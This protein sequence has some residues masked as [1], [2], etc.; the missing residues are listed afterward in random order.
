MKKQHILIIGGGLAG[1]CSAIQCIDA[2]HSV[3]LIDKG[4]NRSSLVA[5]GMINP[6]VFRR[7][8]K[9][10]RVDE[11]IPYS[12][13][14]YRALEHRT[15]ASFFHPIV[16]RRCIASEQEAD[17]WQKRATDPSFC[18]YIQPFDEEDAKIL[19]EQRPF[20]SARVKHSAYVAAEQ[21]MAAC[22]ALIQENAMYID[23]AFDFEQF[24]PTTC[25]Y[26]G[27]VYDH[28]VFCEGSESVRNP[29]FEKLP[30]EATKGEILTVKTQYLSLIHI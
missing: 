29:Y 20:G 22:K 6:L 2:G 25:T 7:M 19:P 5:A 12:E 18:E 15:G 1:I 13:Q 10:W 11:F 3:T 30:V 27:K 17:Y 21:F 26:L 4:T 23:A 8:T 28:A 9:S 24:E 16:I 14:F